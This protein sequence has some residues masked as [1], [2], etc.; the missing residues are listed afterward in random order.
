MDD[1]L[2]SGVKGATFEGRLYRSVGPDLKGMPGD[3]LEIHPG[4]IKAN[5]RYTQPGTGGLY[6]STGEK[7]VNA[8]LNTWKIATDGRVMHSFD[9]KIENLLDVSNPQVRKQLGITLDDIIGNNYDVTHKIGEYAK[10]NGY[11]GIIV[12]SARADGGLNIFL[13]DGK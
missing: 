12:P 9:V 10:K 4:N 7:I 5:H 8:E 6:F 2:E 13:F 1:V 3:P 11:N